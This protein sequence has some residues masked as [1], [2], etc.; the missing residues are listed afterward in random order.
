MNTTI[1]RIRQWLADFFQAWTDAG[2][3]AARYWFDE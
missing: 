2:E 1:D 3:A